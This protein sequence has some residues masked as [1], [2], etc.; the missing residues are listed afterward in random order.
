MTEMKAAKC[1]NEK[2]YRTNDTNSSINVARI[3]RFN[4]IPANIS[5]EV[6]T[7]IKK[8]RPKISYG[9]TKGPK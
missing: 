4:A 9:T 7:E 6:F 1:R 5:M 8:I 3:Y 2:H